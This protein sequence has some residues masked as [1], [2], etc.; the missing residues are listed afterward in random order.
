MPTGADQ[1]VH[2]AVPADVLTNHSNLSVDDQRSRVNSAGPLPQISTV[3]HLGK[4]RPQLVGV[5]QAVDE[6]GLRTRGS[7]FDGGGFI[8][9]KQF[10]MCDPDH[11]S[12][13]IDQ[14]GVDRLCGPDPSLGDEPAGRQIVKVLR[15]A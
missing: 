13:Y 15:R 2:H 11:G 5:G 9:R 10:T 14:D 6:G 8:S 12:L 1:F 7:G 3:E 4:Q